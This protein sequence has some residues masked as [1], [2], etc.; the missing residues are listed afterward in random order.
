MRIIAKLQTAPRCLNESPT[1]GLEA[2]APHK[3]NMSEL[4][5][6]QMAGNPN[7]Q[8][9]TESTEPDDSL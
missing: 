9:H 6:E 8:N 3:T 1:A 2:D 4:G 7:Q 5:G